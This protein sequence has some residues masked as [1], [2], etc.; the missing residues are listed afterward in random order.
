MRE[1]I[2]L[3]LLPCRVVW[4]LW[5]KME[6]ELMKVAPCSSLAVDSILRVGTAGLIWG[7]CIA[8]YDARKQG[9]TAAARASYVVCSL[10][11]SLLLTRVPNSI[12]DVLSVIFGFPKILQAKTI[13][14]HGLICGLVGGCFSG[15][16]C[17]L[18]RY[19]QKNDWVNTLVAG[20]AAGAVAAART[21]S[22]PT[23]VMS[24]GGASVV[25]AMVDYSTSL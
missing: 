20:A 16:R 19:R 18:Q 12:L 13:G 23:V 1:T 4:L 14:G 6:E 2:A 22:L 11:L 9:L 7:S 15:T 17:A 24:A 8:P 3:Y 25:A 10:Y 5:R 21:R